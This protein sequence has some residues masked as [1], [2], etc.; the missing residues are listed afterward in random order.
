MSA[1]EVIDRLVSNMFHSAQLDKDEFHRKAK[2][3]IRKTFDAYALPFAVLETDRNL[4][5][6]LTRIVSTPI[7]P[8]ASITPIPTGVDPSQNYYK[9]DVHTILIFTLSDC[10]TTD[11]GSSSRG[12]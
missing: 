2:Q 8:Q 9:C 3:T 4:R 1:V 6:G 10:R 5:T 11:G 7:D 12:S